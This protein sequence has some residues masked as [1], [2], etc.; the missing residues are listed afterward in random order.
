MRSFLAA[1]I[2]VFL[3]FQPL[4]A[5][6]DSHYTT[7]L[8]ITPQGAANPNGI[9]I[10]NASTG[11]GTQYSRIATISGCNAGS[12]GYAGTIESL[13]DQGVTYKRCVDQSGDMGISGNL[14]IPLNGVIG[15]N[16]AVNNQINIGTAN[17]NTFLREYRTSGG[18]TEIATGGCANSGIWCLNNYGGTGNLFTVDA[19]GNVVALN[20]LAVGGAVNA[21]GIVGGAGLQFTNSDVSPFITTIYGDGSHTVS[22]ITANVFGVLAQSGTQALAVNATGDLGVSRNLAIGGAA[23][24]GAGVGVTGNITASGT[25][26]VGGAITANSGIGVTGNITASGTIAASGALSGTGYSGGPISGTTGTFSST[27]TSPSISKVY[28]NGSQITAPLIE[29]LSGT[30]VVGTTTLVLAA[31]WTVPP[32]CTG[33]ISN[34][35]AGHSLAIGTTTTTGVQIA[36]AAVDTFNLTCVGK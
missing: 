5:L 20:N 10:G 15:N 3:A 31:P 35:T 14:G 29:S 8:I 6:A 12:T 30:T 33:T 25:L 1:F 2:A 4:S 19:S 24:I 13:D 22:G 7:Q 26:G 28:F 11:G 23:T 21:T 9:L 34:G 36:D 17:Q 27:V 16:Q 18:V 32:Q